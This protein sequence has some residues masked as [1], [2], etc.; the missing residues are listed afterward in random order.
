[1]TGHS[2]ITVGPNSDSTFPI[3]PEVGLRT[4]LTALGATLT[5]DTSP[6]RFYPT[7]GTYFSFTSDFFSQTLGSKYS[8]QSYKTKFDSYWSLDDQ[9]LAY[10]GYVCVRLA[11][12]SSF[13]RELHLWDQ[14]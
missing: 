10:D 3:P 7:S 12:G 5:R 1:M 11:R 8:F 6:N 13:L 2:F 4:T 14:Q 9:V